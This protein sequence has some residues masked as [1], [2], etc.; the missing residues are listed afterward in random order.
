MPQRYGLPATSRQACQLSG[1]SIPFSRIRSSWAKP[2]P[3]YGGS[4]YV[5]GYYRKNGTYVRGSLAKGWGVYDN[6][7]ATVGL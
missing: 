1:A 5:G 6:F 7:T 3:S 2:A 4:V